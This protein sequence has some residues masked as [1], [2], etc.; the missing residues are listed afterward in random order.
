M[1]ARRV[2]LFPHLFLVCSILFIFSSPSVSN[3]FFKIPQTPMKSLDPFQAQRQPGRVTDFRVKKKGRGPS[4]HQIPTRKSVLF[5]PSSEEVETQLRHSPETPGLST[6]Q[7]SPARHPPS[8]REEYTSCA[9]QKEV[10]KESPHPVLATASGSRRLLH[11]RRQFSDM[12]RTLKCLPS[13]STNCIHLH[14]RHC[15]FLHSFMPQ[16]RKRKISDARL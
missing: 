10:E 13:E 12:S 11:P 15:H 6:D 14:P 7:I 2:G 1:S 9:S 4:A 3:H 5:P 16:R 8:K